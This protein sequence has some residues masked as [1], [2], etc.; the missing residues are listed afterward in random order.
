[1][2]DP[3]TVRITLRPGVKFTDGS[4]YDTE[5]MRASLLGSRKPRDPSSRRRYAPR[6]QRCLRTSLPSTR[7]PS[8]RLN[9]PLGGQFL[10]DIS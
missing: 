8:R 2:V 1:M 6:D 9:Q 7:S 3:H 10:I 4:T 5:T